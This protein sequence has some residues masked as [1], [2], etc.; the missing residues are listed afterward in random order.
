MKNI[1]INNIS[2]KILYFGLYNITFL[3]TFIIFISEYCIINN[4]RLL[5]KNIIQSIMKSLAL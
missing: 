5:N 2:Q 4:I 1:I 3:I